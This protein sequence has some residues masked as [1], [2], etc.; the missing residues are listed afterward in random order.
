MELEPVVKLAKIEK[1]V[2]IIERIKDIIISILSQGFINQ[3][4]Y[5]VNAKN[6]KIAIKNKFKGSDNA[7]LQDSECSIPI[8]M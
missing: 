4:L 8:M 7:N 6:T 3:L 2:R 5:A 1:P